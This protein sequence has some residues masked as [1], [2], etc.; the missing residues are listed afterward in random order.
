MTK[1]AVISDLHVHNFR[2]FGGARKSG[3]NERCQVV[4]DAVACAITAAH[5]EAATQLVVTGD[6]FDVSDP[7]PQVQ[8]ALIDVL[9]T[10]KGDVHLLVGNHDQYSMDTGDHALGPLWGHTTRRDGA[11]LVHEEVT[12]L[13]ELLF[14]PFRPEPVQHWLAKAIAEHEG[15]VHTV[16]AHFGVSDERTP[17][18]LQDSPDSI[19][20]IRL[21]KIM[22]RYGIERFVVGN[23][24]EHQIWRKLGSTIV[25]VGA[26]VP[27]G[28][29]NLGLAYGRVVLL[30]ETALRV[31]E[32]PGP[33]F[34]TTTWGVDIEEEISEYGEHVNLHVTA[35]PSELAVARAWLAE[36]SERLH[37]VNSRILPNR[38]SAKQ[39]TH[40]AAKAASSHDERDKAVA[41]YVKKMPLAEGVERK[42]V[43]THI[44]RYLDR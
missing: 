16:F 29:G 14:V 25:Q 32:V 7:P 39:L 33:R 1:I 35:E 4:L 11:V 38:E 8:A 31:V 23:W 15:A 40:A 42:K 36:H 5:S 28:F 44:K 30:S 20:A 34:L 26:L 3:I 12:R 9:K 2:V 22:K 10:F 19:S 6:V 37:I 18:W 24:H 13:G 17:S 43:A 41:A 21:F 27:T